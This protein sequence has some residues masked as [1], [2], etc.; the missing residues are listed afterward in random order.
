MCLLPAVILTSVE[1]GRPA[2]GGVGSSC[3]LETGCRALAGRARRLKR[4]AAVAGLSSGAK[5]ARCWLRG[6]LLQ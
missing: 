1:S 6:G 5:P 2:R 4:V 3:R